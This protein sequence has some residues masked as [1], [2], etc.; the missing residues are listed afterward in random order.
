MHQEISECEVTKLSKKDESV[1]KLPTNLMVERFEMLE[2]MLDSHLNEVREFSKKKQDAVLSNLKVKLINRVLTEIKELFKNEST[3]EF[4]D[5]LDDDTLPQNGD[6]VLILGQYK[7][8]MEQYR[9]KYY[10]FDSTIYNHRW[11]TQENPKKR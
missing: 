1:S 8:A 5:L 4:L 2:P 7:A 11:F 6:A 10:G 9:S 3:S